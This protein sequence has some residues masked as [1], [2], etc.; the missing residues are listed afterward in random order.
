M[1]YVGVHMSMLGCR[2][3]R[4]HIRIYD[5]KGIYFGMNGDVCTHTG[6]IGVYGYTG[7]WKDL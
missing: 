3:V 7:I 6:Y 1:Q 4:G 5:Y 2:S